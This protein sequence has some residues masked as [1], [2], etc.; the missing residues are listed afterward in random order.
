[1]RAF[2][3][4]LEPVKEEANAELRCSVKEYREDESLPP[5]K[6]FSFS[7]PLLVEK[8]RQ[9]DLLGF[10]LKMESQNMPERT[11][12]LAV[13]FLPN[14]TI[15]DIKELKIKSKELMR[16]ASN[17]SQN[18]PRVLEIWSKGVGSA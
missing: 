17:Y 8:R 2:R 15:T 1:M 16:I 18:K 13:Q 3:D 7:P 14:K 9:A 11:S 5:K 4:E 12:K 6:Q 10:N